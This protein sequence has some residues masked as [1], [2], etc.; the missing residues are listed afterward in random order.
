MSAGGG[1]L[2]PPPPTSGRTRGGDAPQ[3]ET[4]VQP[5]RYLVGRF[6]SRIAIGDTATL[7]VK[8]SVNPFHGR[9]ERIRDLTVP[10]QG[11]LLDIA[12]QAD[13]FEFLTPQNAPIRLPPTGDSTGAAFDLK[14]LA[15][16]KTFIRISAFHGGTCIG[17]LQIPVKVETPGT[18]P[19][20]PEDVAGQPIGGLIS[21]PGDVA[22]LV[23]FNDKSQAYS[24]TW[25]DKNGAQTPVDLQKSLAEIDV[26]ISGIVTEIQEIVRMDFTTQT[27]VAENS[28]R[29]RGIKI[30]KDL[31]PTPIQSQFIAN[32]TTIKRMMIVS[33]GD[34]IPWEMLYPYVVN[35]RFDHG[36]LVDQVE[37]SRWKFG[38]LPPGAIALRRAD[39]VMPNVDLEMARREVNQVSKLLTGWNASI[40]SHAINKAEELLELL[41]QAI[42]SLLH[43]AC[44]NAYDNTGGRIIV[45]SPVTPGD[46]LSLHDR[47]KEI[48]PFAF[49]NACRTDGTPPEYIRI[50]KKE[51]WAQ[52]FLDM[53]FG[54][55]IGTLWEVRDD[56]AAEFAAAVY[57]ELVKNKSFGDALKHARKTL[58]SEFPGDPTWLAYSFYGASGARVQKV[59]VA[60][61]H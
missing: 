60:P 11:L 28:L 12:V 10:K 22:L 39:F 2:S 40:R 48:A 26:V 14:A 3:P 17:G 45:K 16:R 13:G 46:Y 29:Q 25:Q 19:T 33:D 58:R 43:F 9:A 21:R 54:A 35:P 56:S 18:V 61:T 32:C 53:G 51:G 55:F 42:V 23:A 6:P 37:L 5:P 38:S 49:M 7:S 47:L 44:H 50:G 52:C 31:I 8:I 41:D 20:S 34:P 4:R 27:K 1:R 24:F 15:E 59:A 36:F 57:T 30:W